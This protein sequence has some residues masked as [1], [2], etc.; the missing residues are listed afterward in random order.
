VTIFHKRVENL[1]LG[2]KANWALAQITLI[3]DWRCVRGAAVFSNRTNLEAPMTLYADSYA[4]HTILHHPK[5]R[6]RV[7]LPKVRNTPQPL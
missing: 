2:K 7:S 3:L 1:Y 5:R 4:R 6:T